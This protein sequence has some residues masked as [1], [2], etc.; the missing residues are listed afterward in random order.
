MAAG[1]SSMAHAAMSNTQENGPAR[2]GWQP[3]RPGQGHHEQQGSE[4]GDQPASDGDGDC[5]GTTGGMDTMFDRLRDAAA[6]HDGDCD[7]LPLIPDGAA[8]G[9][10]PER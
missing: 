8:T 10:Q 5:S 9:I 4:G 1:H 3:S 2:P 7:L 6:K